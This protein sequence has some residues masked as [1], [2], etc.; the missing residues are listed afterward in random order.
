MIKELIIEQ[1]IMNKTNKKLIKLL[2][3]LRKNGHDEEAE[4]IEE[5]SNEEEYSLPNLDKS[6]LEGKFNLIFKDDYVG[7]PKNFSSIGN[8]VYRTSQPTSKQ[9]RYIIKKFDIKTVIRLNSDGRDTIMDGH[10]GHGPFMNVKRERKIV[11]DLNSEFIYKVISEKG[12][13]L[14]KG[15]SAVVDE[16]VDIIKKGNVLVHCKHGKDRTGAVI[17]SYLK[18]QG[19]PLKEIWRHN[20]MYAPKWDGAD[21]RV[22]RKF[23]NY[24]KYI[25]T[26]YPIKQWCEEIARHNYHEGNW[27]CNLCE[28]LF[29]FEYA[30]DY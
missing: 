5:L 24:W 26:F 15:Y 19:V 28:K 10:F 27:N 6:E 8:G 18:S 17:G 22:C 20:I 30:E 29:P 14:G 25:D 11:E 1:V 4:E 13:E 9:L 7:A 12:S 2:N 23:R 3:Y 21:G 16:L